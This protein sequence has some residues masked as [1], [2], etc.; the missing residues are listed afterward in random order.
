MNSTKVILATA[1]ALLLANGKFKS[2]LTQNHS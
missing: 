2:H 1:L